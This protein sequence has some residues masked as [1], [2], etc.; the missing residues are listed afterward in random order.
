MLGHLEG[1]YR[2]IVFCSFSSLYK[3][4]LGSKIFFV[5][6]SNIFISVGIIGEYGRVHLAYFPYV[7]LQ[8]LLNTFRV[9]GKDFVGCKKPQILHILNWERCLKT[10]I[11]VHLFLLRW[12]S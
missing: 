6:W 1:K 3:D 11:Q 9:I 5:F 7:L 12:K 10:G 8:I 4:D 2:E